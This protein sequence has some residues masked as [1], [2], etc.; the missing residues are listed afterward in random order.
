MTS[1]RGS[2]RTE[3]SKYWYLPLVAAI[4]YSTAGMHVYGMGPAIQSLQNAFGWSRAQTLAGSAMVSLVVAAASVPMGTIIDR[5]GPRRVALLGVPLIGIAVALL[6]TATG[7]RANWFALWALVAIA[8]IPVQSTTW[9]M[10]VVSRFDASRGLALAFTLSGG[11]LGAF[12]FPLISTWLVQ[13]FGWRYAFIGLGGLWAVF[14]LP[15]VALWFRSSQDAARVA[16]HDTHAASDS[17]PGITLREA[18]RHSMFYRLFFATGFFTFSI[19]GAIVNIYPILTD[20]GAAPMTA[21]SAAS[22]VGIFS[23]IG[24]LATGVT[25]DRF[26]ANIV[27][28]VCFLMPIPACALLLSHTTGTWSYF[29]ATALLGLSLG[30]EVDVVSYLIT[31]RFGLKNFGAIQGALLVATALGSASGP[32]T[33]GATFDRFGSYA[34]FLSATIVLML[35]SAFVIGTARS[36]P[37]R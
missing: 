27:G 18:V 6:G 37:A 1:P 25:L 26:R 2:A 10:A 23:F 30:A 29:V 21:A 3:W 19:F 14:T 22:L 15:F 31:R 24:R 12:V 20:R 16:A 5:L 11:S 35:F 33:A 34:H 32:I 9:N 17:L 36:S 8:S 13:H 7:T 28:A 4:G